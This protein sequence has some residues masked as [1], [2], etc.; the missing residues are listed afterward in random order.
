[1]A[2]HYCI[3][4]ADGRSPG[5]AAIANAPAAKRMESAMKYRQIL[6][7]LGCSLVGQAAAR[8]P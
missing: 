6:A 2:N 4:P 3:L 1:M 7:L 5:P 8:A